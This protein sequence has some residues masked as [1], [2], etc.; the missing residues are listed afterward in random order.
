[1][2]FR[3]RTLAATA[4]LCALLPAAALARPPAGSPTHAQISTAGRLAGIPEQ[5]QI[6]AAGQRAGTPTRAQIRAAVKRAKRSRALWATVNICNTRHHPHALGIRG[7]MPALGFRARLSMRIAVDYWDPAKKRFVADK[8]VRS[9][10]VALGATSSELRQGG[11]EFSFAPPAVL[12]GTVTFK[13]TV[14]RH[15]V[16]R[17]TRATAHGIRG[18]DRG[19]PRGYSAA[20]CQILH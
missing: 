10:V 11:Y 8:S 19:D 3:V 12:S 1:M 16:G 6:S 18:V 7:Q 20:T 13:W 4:M 15:V 2:F 17:A 5:A 9:K 14:G